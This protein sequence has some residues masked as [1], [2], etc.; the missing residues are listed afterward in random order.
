MT[1]S[2]NQIFVRCSNSERVA[3]ALRNYVD[4][5]ADQFIPCSSVLLEGVKQVLAA[6]TKKKRVFKLCS[7]GEWTVI[8]EVVHYSDFADPSVARFVSEQLRTEAIWI[9]MDYDYNIWAFQDFVE[10]EVASEIFLP[11]TYF[12]GLPESEQRFDYGSCYDHADAF[13][14]TR[15]LPL[16]LESVTSAERRAVVRR[17]ITTIKC[18]M[19]NT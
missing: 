10:G 13:N 1:K 4:K 8:W 12:N 19:T 2:A 9:Y 15:S 7:N 3:D 16:F 18:M 17:K 14:A 5:Y 11:E 6:L